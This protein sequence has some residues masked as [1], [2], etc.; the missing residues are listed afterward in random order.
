MD[1]E[2]NRCYIPTTSHSSKRSD[3]N[4]D[5]T[6]ANVGGIKGETIR[7]GTSDHWPI[8]LTCES[9]GFDKNKMFPRVHWKAYEAILTLLQGFWINE[10][11]RR[12]PADEWYVNYVRFLSP[13]KNR[14]TEWKEKERYRPALPPYLIQKLKEIKRVRNKYYRERNMYNTNE[15]TRVL[16]RVLTR[17]VRTEIA[18]YKSNN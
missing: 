10:Q 9:V 15:N 12:M 1:R 17:E 13:L 11:D 7:T 3:R 5:L 14:L 18:K 4:I 2:K 8:I 6:F 16:L